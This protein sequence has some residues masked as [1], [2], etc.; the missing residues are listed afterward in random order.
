MIKMLVFKADGVSGGKWRKSSYSLESVLK[1][2]KDARYWL[3]T[4]GYI[5][6]HQAEYF[7]ADRT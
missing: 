4:I 5:K 7:D 3:K 1:D 6:I 2:D